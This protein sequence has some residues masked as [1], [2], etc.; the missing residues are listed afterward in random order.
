M[1]S[2]NTSK[3]IS[4]ADQHATVPYTAN[5]SQKLAGGWSACFPRAMKHV[6]SKINAKLALLVFSI[7]GGF[8]LPTGADQSQG[9]AAA[10]PGKNIVLVHAA[11]A[12]G[13]SSAKI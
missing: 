3:E 7:C 6:A 8:A 10:A 12:G 1:N 11:F 9:A 4:R 2:T 5:R 13:S